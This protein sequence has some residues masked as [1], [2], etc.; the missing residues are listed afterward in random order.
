M[1]TKRPLTDEEMARIQEVATA[2]THYGVLSL[3]P[4]AS[5][6]TVD[7]AYRAYVREWHP[8]RFYS[9]ECGKLK[10]VIEQNFVNVTQ[11]YDVLRD[12]RKR[13]DYD[14][15][16]L[17][18]GKMPGSRPP[19]RAAPPKPPP[20]PEVPGHEVVFGKAASSPP[21][22]ASGADAP[23]L[24]TPPAPPPPPS[25]TNL[26]VQRL[27]AQLAEQNAKAL[28]YVQSAK[29]DFEAGHYVKAEG[30]LYLALKLAPQNV[31]A[32]TLYRQATEKAKLHRAEQ[33]IHQAEQAEQYGRGKEALGYYQ[34]ACECDP[35][36]G[37]AWF[38]LARIRKSLGEEDSPKDLLQLYKKAS[39][40]SPKV[41]E[42][43]MAAAEGYLALDMV[44]NAHREALA[45]LE[46]DP[47]H[48]AAKVLVKK[49]RT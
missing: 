10:P 28:M 30:A 11:A 45:A 2:S 31:E 39:M 40:K 5:R 3:S 33:L 8:D 16:I 27:R 46:L 14:Q 21:S 19:A 41:L 36:D 24:A 42:Y 26:A 12:E 35:P 9:R 13:R 47:K 18:S 34:K 22:A 25:P 43:R 20:A 48:E 32:Q 23:R 4:G 44:A 15:E 1:S 29:S 38:C 49:T 7:S 6:E 37:K 17:V